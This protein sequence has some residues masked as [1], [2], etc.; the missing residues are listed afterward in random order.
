MG[1]L[2]WLNVRHYAKGNYKEE[3]EDDESDQLWEL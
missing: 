3:S 1:E 2:D